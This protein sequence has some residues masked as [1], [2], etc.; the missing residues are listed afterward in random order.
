MATRRDEQSHNKKSDHVFIEECL[1]SFLQI[2]GNYMLF[3]IDIFFFWISWKLLCI[4]GILYNKTFR[5]NLDRSYTSSA[6]AVFLVL[7]P[8]F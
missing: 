6:I 7:E 5:G 1:N 3:S 4:L 8:H 2:F